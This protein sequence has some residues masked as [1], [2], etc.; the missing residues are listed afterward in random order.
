MW[1]MNNEQYWP[2]SRS[3]EEKLKGKQADFFNRKKILTTSCQ[4]GHL[5]SAVNWNYAMYHNSTNTLQAVE[6]SPY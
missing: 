6:N 1:A 2:R 3:E 5:P 4:S